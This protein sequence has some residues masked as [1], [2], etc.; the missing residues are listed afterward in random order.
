LR[1]L[2]MPANACVLGIMALGIIMAFT[3][4]ATRAILLLSRIDAC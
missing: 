4:I 1:Y 3:A 2:L